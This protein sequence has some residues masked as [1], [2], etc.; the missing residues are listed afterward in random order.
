MS[1][2]A[3]K[4]Y[5]TPE[6][7][8]K[9]LD[10]FLAEKTSFARHQIKKIIQKGRCTVN[11]QIQ[12]ASYK[13]KPDD[14]IITLPLEIQKVK[15]IPQNIPLNIVFEDSEIIIIDKDFGRVVHPSVGHP[16]LTLVNALLHHCGTLPESSHEHRPGIVHR[17]DKDTGGLI[18]I[19][20]TPNALTH[21]FQQFKSKTIRRIYYALC[22]GRPKN[23]KGCIESWLIRKAH[24][25][26]KHCSSPLAHQGKKAITHYKVLY[27]EDISLFELQLETGR[28][29][30]IRVHL[31][32]MNHPIIN[33]PI[34]SSKNRIN[35]LTDPRLK[36]MIKK[37][38]TMYLYAQELQLIHPKTQK[39]MNFKSSLP[40][41]FT[42]LLEYR[43]I[44]R[45]SK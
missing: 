38:Q 4:F 29:H 41:S 32:E 25:R 3:L 44:S 11:T 30:Q 17:L 42:E 13:L 33:D 14:V 1:L 28:T 37:A 6:D 21:L 7:S 16:D 34:Y 20:K 27:A 43:N 31:S 18:V 22:F 45:D 15:L 39:L 40:K 5:I 10:R 24:D 19:A 23:L 2:K 35:S 8:Q 26:L 9:R 12:K 36:S